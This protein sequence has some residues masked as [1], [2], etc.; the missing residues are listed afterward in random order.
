MKQLWKSEDRAMDRLLR[1]HMSLQSSPKEPC[2]QFDP[3]LANAYIE[4]SLTPTER[5]GFQQHTS[6]CAYCRTATVSLERLASAEVPALLSRPGRQMPAERW[7][8][9]LG[10]LAGAMTTPRWAMAAAAVIVLAVSI[11]VLLSRTGTG[12]RPESGQETATVQS[13]A[14]AET[15]PQTQAEPTPPSGKVRLDSAPTPSVAPGV[16]PPSREQADQ[17][18]AKNQSPAEQ[19]QRAP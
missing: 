5:E 15:S 9:R 8:E 14:R 2:K 10:A 7:R 6:L 3:D 16:G 18:L 4:K 13:L 1:G 19:D 11:P 12:N 17:L